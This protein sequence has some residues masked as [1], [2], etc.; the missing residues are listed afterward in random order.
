[1]DISDAFMA[2]AI[3]RANVAL[4]DAE[5]E[6]LQNF[7]SEVVTDYVNTLGEGVDNVEQTYSVAVHVAGLAFTA[8][9]AY[10]EQFSDRGGT[11]PLDVDK[12]T[13]QAFLKFLAEKTQL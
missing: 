1:M 11:F 6:E 4:D 7:L 5:A 3:E 2:D 9:R 13:L 12:D 10:E 8:G